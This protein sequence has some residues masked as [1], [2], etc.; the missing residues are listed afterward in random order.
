MFFVRTV[1]QKLS[2]LGDANNTSPSSRDG[3]DL[4]EEQGFLA[5]SPLPLDS[6]ANL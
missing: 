3:L 1:L 6:S 5:K 2:G 4:G